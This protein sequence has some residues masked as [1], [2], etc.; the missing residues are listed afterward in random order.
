MNIKIVIIA[1][2]SIS[3]GLSSAVS[4]ADKKGGKILV[5][6]LVGSG[7][8]YERTVPDIDGDDVDDPAICFDVDLINSKNGQQVG[9]ATDCLSNITPIG[10]GLGLVGTTYFNLPQGNLVTRGNT[11]VQPVTHGITTAD[12][13]LITHVTGAAGTENAILEGTGR[14]RNSTGTVRLS[15]MVDMTNFAGNP[16][17]PIAFD[18]LFV[19]ILD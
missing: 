8:M 9:T 17:E 11:T 19:I 13:Q 4:A 1:V 15:G 3:L 6:N 12:G 5:M 18:C 10:S 7:A 14:F 16:G 2:I